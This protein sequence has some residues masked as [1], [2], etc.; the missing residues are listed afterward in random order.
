MDT[1]EI[2]VFLTG[3]IFMGHLAAAL[4]FLGFWR[5]TRERLFAWFAAAFAVL[6]AERVLLLWHIG[7]DV[8]PTVYTA[9]LVAFLLIIVAVV[10]H[11]RRTRD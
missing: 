9:R 2:S 6:M 3:A 4:M 7:G 10:D 5:R 11:N 1:H 8:H